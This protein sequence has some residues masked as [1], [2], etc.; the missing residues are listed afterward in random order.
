VPGVAASRTASADLVA[1]APHAREAI[2]TDRGRGEHV[3]AS[4]RADPVRQTLV[5]VGVLVFREGRLLLGRRRGSHGADS[6]APPGG[7][8]DFGESAEACARRELAE[9]T[10]LVVDRVE[11]GPYTVDTFADEGRHYVTLFVVAA[12][13]VGEP[14]LLEP[15]R[16]EGWEWHDWRELPTP[17]FAPLASL[18]AR[19]FVPPASGH[20]TPPSP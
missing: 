20:R 13:A 3:D 6:W 8:L 9:E 16:C 15:D 11:A 18:R 4:D 14:S 5:G 1:R 2:V 7:H 10:G 19:G 17:L 12:G